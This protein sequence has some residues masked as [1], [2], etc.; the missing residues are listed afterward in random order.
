MGMVAALQKSNGKTSARV[1]TIFTRLLS[2]YLQIELQKDISMFTLGLLQYS[3]VA[4][5]PKK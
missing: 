4:L 2:T 5:N 1:E 3:S